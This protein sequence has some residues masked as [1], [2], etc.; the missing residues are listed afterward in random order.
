M[1]VRGGDTSLFSLPE[2]SMTP[3]TSNASMATTITSQ[4]SSPQPH[5]VPSSDA[6]AV[7][8]TIE[9]LTTILQRLSLSVK[10]LM[11]TTG[12]AS[13]PEAIRATEEMKRHYLQLMQLKNSDLNAV[14]DAFFQSMMP[15]VR[16]VSLEDEENVAPA[17]HLLRA[18]D[19]G[20]QN[21]NIMTTTDVVKGVSHRIE[22]EEEDDDLR[23]LVG[24]NDYEECADEREGPESE[25]RDFYQQ[26]SCQV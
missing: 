9:F 21:N 24:S 23:R 20:V 22:E 12:R 10:R 7:R 8:R 3:H 25:V 26:E 4:P 18:F 11:E 17:R 19:A 1:T 14:S 15:L 16:T 13:S 5:N 2:E 6:V